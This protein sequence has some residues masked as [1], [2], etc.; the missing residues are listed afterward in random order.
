MVRGDTAQTRFLGRV[1]RASSAA[2]CVEGLAAGAVTIS[3]D[4]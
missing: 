3:P 1:G 2:A 4:P